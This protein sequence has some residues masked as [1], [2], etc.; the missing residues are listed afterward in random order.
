MKTI[1]V[2]TNSKNYDIK[3]GNDLLGSIPISKLVS[4]KDVLL[5]IDN[6]IPE[7]LI[8]KFK[9][10]LKKS[11]AKKIS[12]IKIRAAEGNKNMSYIMKI[13]DYLIKNNY[14]RDCIVF[15]FGGG[16]T[17]DITGFIA[18]TFLR[19]VDFVLIP[20]TL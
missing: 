2:K 16:I 13:Y 18:S 12:L 15:G 19:G 8:N 17:C 11:S 6:K 7:L 4:G 1:K 10:N 14:S 5:I 20:S 9:K 3:V